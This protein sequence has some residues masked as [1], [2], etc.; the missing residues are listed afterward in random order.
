MNAVRPT[1]TDFSSIVCF[2]AL[3]VGMEETLG[4]PAAAV[5][6]KAAGRKRGQAL[7][8]GLGLAGKAPASG[9][10][11]GALNAAIG[12]EGTRLCGVDKVERAGDEFRVYLSETICSAD[13]APGSS[14]ELTFTFGA[15]H[16]A[17]E[18]LYG[19]KLRGKQVGS[20]LRGDTHDIVFLEP[21]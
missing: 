3:V 8:D 18:A 2:R 11:A 10:L 6:L 16:G 12:R 13:E 19:M 5:A 17:V 14:R 15:V 1:L 20:V 21:R 4:K 9:E 7:V